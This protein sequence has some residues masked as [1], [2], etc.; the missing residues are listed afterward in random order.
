MG[1][2]PVLIFYLLLLSETKA[3]E[4]PEIKPDRKWPA[5]EAYIRPRVK[6]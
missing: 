6:R 1:A 5:R 3:H 2:I 4:V